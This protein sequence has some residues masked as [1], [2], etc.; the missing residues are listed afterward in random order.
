MCFWLFHLQCTNWKY[1][2]V[3]KNAQVN[4]STTLGWEATVVSSIVCQQRPKMYAMAQSQRTK[5]S[6]S[7][8]DAKKCNHQTPHGYGWQSWEEEK[9]SAHEVPQWWW[10]PLIQLWKVTI[11]PRIRA[12]RLVM[13]VCIGLSL[14]TLFFS[15]IV[16]WTTSMYLHDGQAQAT[17]MILT[18]SGSQGQHTGQSLPCCKFHTFTHFYSTQDVFSVTGG[19][20]EL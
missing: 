18:S 20:V 17:L 10:L 14:R 6:V 16:L 15:L 2:W 5:Q 11:W 12:Q 19:Q 3:V 4:A 13:S 8:K 9:I 1:T 7:L